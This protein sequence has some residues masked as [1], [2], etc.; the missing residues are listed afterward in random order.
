MNL[1]YYRRGFASFAGDFNALGL[2]FFFQGR[3]QLGVGVEK[4]TKLDF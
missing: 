1:K 2:F 3:L 4:V